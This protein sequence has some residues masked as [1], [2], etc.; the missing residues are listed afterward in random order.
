MTAGVTLSLSKGD[1]GPR[2][3]ASREALRKRHP[4]P[5]E[6]CPGSV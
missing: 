6:G 3:S 4:E 5:V 1:Q 2:Q